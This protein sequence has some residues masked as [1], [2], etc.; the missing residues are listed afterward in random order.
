ME[1]DVVCT[2][3][4]RDITGTYLKCSDCSGIVLCM[5]CFCSGAE[6]G[7]HKKTHGYRIKTTSRNTAVPIFGNWDANEE[8]HLLDALE[9]YGIGNWEDVSLK[10]ETKD[11]TECM[12]HYCTYYL[13]SVLGQNLLCE[14][15]RISRVTDHTNQTSQ[16]SP[17]LLQ[18]SPSVQIEIEDQQLLGYMPARGD[19]ERDY[20]NDAESILCRLHPSF[21]HDD[22]EDSLKVAQVGIYLQRLRERQRRKEI[23]REHGLISQILA[24]I[25]NRRLKRRTAWNKQ[26]KPNTQITPKRRGRPPSPRKQ[27][28]LD[29]VQVQKNTPIKRTS[30]DRAVPGSERTGSP[31]PPGSWLAAPFILKATGAT[32]GTPLVAS[33]IQ[34]NIGQNVTGQTSTS[35]SGLRSFRSTSDLTCTTENHSVICLND[36]LKPFIRYFTGPQGKQFMDSLYHEEVLKHEIKYLLDCRAK[37][38]LKFSAIKLKPPPFRSFVYTAPPKPVSTLTSSGSRQPNSTTKPRKRR[39]A[40]TTPWYIKAVQRRHRQNR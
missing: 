24:F 15:R 27:L 6:A 17:S 34:T 1:P 22:L 30:I 19:F 3:C 28:Q 29:K 10:V 7:A 40:L 16:L 4:L 14:G 35:R 20:D 8:R 11:P 25:L 31:P 37:G 9:H 36:K 2:Y 13:D 23:A 12:Q 21:S 32:R 18:T 26:K 5:V 39:R 38:K 33:G